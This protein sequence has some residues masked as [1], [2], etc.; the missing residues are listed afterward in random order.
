MTNHNGSLLS[1][2][3]V[4][5]VYGTK[6]ALK[7]LSFS[8][9][10]GDRIALLGIN[11]A[12]KSS[13]LNI[14]TGIRKASSGDVRLFGQE[15]TKLTSRRELGYLPQNLQ[16]PPFLRVCEVIQTI[17][18]HFETPND[19]LVDVLDLRELWHA[20]IGSLS[21][22]Q[23]RRVALVCALISRPKLA[24]LDEASNGMDIAMRSKVFDVLSDYF[25][26]HGRALVF[27][28]HHMDEV[29]RLAKHVLVINE[30]RIIEQ[31]SVDQIKQ[32]YGLHRL[33]FKSDQ[34]DINLDSASKIQSKNGYW[35]AYASNK[36]PLIKE[37]VHKVPDATEI[38][39][40]EASLEEVFLT[41]TQDTL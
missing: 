7:D 16:F 2:A 11:G 10:P 40:H 37:M 9:K 39:V 14:S 24:L 28:T 30:G 34:S 23:S 33:V 17:S 26:D 12:G 25:S 29:E 13:L 32:R 19:E 20:S 6:I 4:S 41:L 36:D 35:H 8:V 18:R 1:F 21:G 5:K 27:S 38:S 22:G 3:N 15:P 31:G